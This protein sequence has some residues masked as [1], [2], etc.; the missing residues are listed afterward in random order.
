MLYCWLISSFCDREEERTL[1]FDVVSDPEE[2]RSVGWCTIVASSIIQKDADGDHDRN[3]DVH[4]AP[5][6]LALELPSMVEELLKEAQ[7]VV[8]SKPHTPR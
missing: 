3:G 2:R 1:L 7:G 4:D 8:A 5:R 6:N